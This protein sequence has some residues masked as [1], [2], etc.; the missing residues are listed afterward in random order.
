MHRLDHKSRRE[1]FEQREIWNL[2]FLERNNTQYSYRYSHPHTH[3]HIHVHFI[4]AGRNF[5]VA[6]GCQAPLGTLILPLCYPATPVSPSLS[7]TTSLCTSTTSL[8][9]PPLTCTEYLRESLSRS[10]FESVFVYPLLS[11]LFTIFVNLFP[12]W[13]ERELM[14]IQIINE[15]SYIPQSWKIVWIISKTTFIS[16]VRF[17]F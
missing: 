5:R 9:L 10:V 3:T 14:R 13:R 16:K 7:P 4:P 12:R 1:L 6:T 11:D 15:F 2:K 17:N 8:L